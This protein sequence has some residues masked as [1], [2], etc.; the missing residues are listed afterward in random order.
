M[1]ISLIAAISNNLVIGNKN[2]IPWNLPEDLKWFKKNTIYKNII[3]G[4]LTW[5]SIVNFL[6]MRTNIVISRKKIVKK[7][8]I[9]ANS[10]QNAIIS[11]TYS[12]YNQNQ[13]VMV[14]G[15]GEIYKQMLF[16]A[17]K[18]YLTHVNCNIIGDSY[19]PKYKLYKNWK[20]IFKKQFFKDKKHSYDFYFEIL[21]R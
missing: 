21:V 1:N 6:P 4:R 20:T 14:I 13:E 12:K 2:K 5:E 19:F 11:T 8:I 17:N 3:M 18:L 16:Y 9:W 7:N 15:G 10:I